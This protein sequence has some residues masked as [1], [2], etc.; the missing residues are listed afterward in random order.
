[1]NGLVGFMNTGIGRVARVVLGLVLVALGLLSLQGTAGTILAVVGLV[2][3]VMGIWGRCLLE[4]V[5][6]KPASSR[7]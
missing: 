3:I 4:L 1:M 6:P 2:P 7:A 5:S